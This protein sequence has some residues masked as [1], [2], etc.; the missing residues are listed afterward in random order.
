MI[1]GN[2]SCPSCD[3]HKETKHIQLGNELILDCPFEHFDSVRWFK[4]S[5]LIA[6]STSLRLFNISYGHQGK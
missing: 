4:D 2:K 1:S 6:N 3:P 5:K